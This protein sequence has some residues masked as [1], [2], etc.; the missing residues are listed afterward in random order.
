M[1]ES[2]LLTLSTNL[3]KR[4]ILVGFCVSLIAATPGCTISKKECLADDWQTTGYKDGKRGKSADVIN[5]YAKTCA[6]HGVT[7][8]ALA[9]SAGFDVGIVEYCTPENGFSEGEDN[10]SYS[11]ACPAELETAFL[12]NYVSGLRVA[13]DDLAI[14]YDRDQVALDRLR[15]KRDRLAADGAS[16]TKEDKLI[17]STSSRLSRNASKRSSINDKIRRW[18]RKL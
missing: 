16:T 1:M 2:S 17:K 9:Y 6:K 11:G 5:S 3:F 10:D 4:L 18:S 12:E 8:D 15:D 7:P 13:L 14:D